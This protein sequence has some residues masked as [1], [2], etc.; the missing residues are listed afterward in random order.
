M[1][2]YRT[3]NLGNV[4]QSLMLDIRKLRRHGLIRMGQHATTTW[5]WSWSYTSEPAGSISLAA[6]LLDPRNPFV[7]LTYWVN[8]EPRHQNIALAKRPMRFGGYRY[9]FVCPLSGRRCEVIALARGLFASAR[10]SRLSYMSQNQSESDRVNT[11]LR[12]LENRI[13]PQKKPRSAPR[14]KRRQRMLARLEALTEKSE[15]NLVSHLARLFG[16][17]DL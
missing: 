6:N 17:L 2:R 13:W 15:A 14:G 3:Q 8:D 7:A 16:T 10:S 5:T 4:E 11:S 1:G 9:Y 12:K